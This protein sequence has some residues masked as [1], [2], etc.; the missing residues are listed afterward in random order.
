VPKALKL[1]AVA[2]TLAASLSCVLP[3][4]S[5]AAWAASSLQVQ[6]PAGVIE[7]TSL[8]AGDAE[9]RV[10]KGIPYAAP[11][12]G[13]LR[14]K[15]PQPLAQW[16]GVRQTTQFGPRCMQLHVSEKFRFRSEG[17]SEDC[18]SLNVWTPAR[19]ADEKLPVLVYFHGGAL[20]AG[21]G[22]DPRYDGASLAARGIVTVTVNY[23][24]GVFGFLALPALA[25]ES[26]HRATGNYGLLDQTAA[27]T[28]VREN[29]A[30]FG[31]DPQQV[32][33]AGDATGSMSVNAHMASP[34]SRGLFARA[35]GESG[36]AFG[37]EASWDRTTAEIYGFRFA[38]RTGAKTLDRLREL[39]AQT[40]LDTTDGNGKAIAFWPVVDGHFLRRRPE[41]VFTTGEQARVP[42]LL[43][44]NSQEVSYK[45]LLKDAE[46]TPEN[47]RA[48]IKKHFPSKLDEVL[49]LYPGHDKD[50]VMRSASALGSDIVTNNQVWRWMESHRSAHVPTYFY[51]YTHPLPPKLGAPPNERPAT[52]AVHAAQIEYA[53]GNLDSEPLYAWSAEDRDVSRIFSG[54]V[55]QFVKTGNPN[56]PQLPDWR[57][58]REEEGGV[59]RQM[60]GVSTHTEVARE[61]ARQAF[62]QANSPTGST[63][64]R[65]AQ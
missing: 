45:S 47:W 56:G 54:Y 9:L 17:M 38:W 62:V 4:V 34:L 1:R 21:D 19:A 8:Q 7:G 60:I 51:R 61:A 3:G 49:A 46:P 14:W 30:R 32:T 42:L 37:N 40:L 58:A 11:P 48:V 33:I 43:G 53:L 57:A 28:W 2:A 15:E 59:L 6:L 35:I 26:P 16:S 36:A 22:S 64:E 20:L 63:A 27:L 55:T 25:E 5:H 50:E 31:G 18:L 39:P 65:L 24:L 52:G 13:V 10:F 41:A 12:V 44:S 29:I 23:R